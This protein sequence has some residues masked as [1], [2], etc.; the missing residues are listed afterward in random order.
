M[1][2]STAELGTTPESMTS[3]FK[4]GLS[5]MW[6]NTLSSA[7]GLK[8]ELSL[9][10]TQAKNKLTNAFDWFITPDFPVS[11][12]LDRIGGDFRDQMK[13]KILAQN[14]KFLFSL[15][16]GFSLGGLAG[17]FT[18]GASL[19]IVAAGLTGAL[20]G[21]FLETALAKKT[22]R[23]I[24]EEIIEKRDILTNYGRGRASRIR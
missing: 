16:S 21:G 19:E 3:V 12:T 4:R 24:K 10:K 17:Q 23:K 20:A 14:A 11:E 22:M 18:G 13:L 8:K 15:F 9:L 1:E 7:P 6:E 5:S 2:Q